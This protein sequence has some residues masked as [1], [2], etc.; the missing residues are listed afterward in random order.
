MKKI[1]LILSCLILLITSGI[2]FLALDVEK[3]SYLFLIIFCVFLAIDVIDSITKNIK[4]T[5]LM[6]ITVKYIIIGGLLIISGLF[7]FNS[8]YPTVILLFTGVNFIIIDI[9]SALFTIF[10]VQGFLEDNYTKMASLKGFIVQ[11]I[12]KI[13]IGI[14]MIIYARLVN[15]DFDMYTKNNIDSIISGIICIIAGIVY[16]VIFILSTKNYIKAKQIKKSFEE[17]ENPEE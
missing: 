11:G 14:L 13:V 9:Y 6:Y 2:I 16:L 17:D 4:N 15:D 12:P 3:T 7:M 10:W 1:L 5:F 8:K